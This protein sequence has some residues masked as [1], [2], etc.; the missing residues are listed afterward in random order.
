MT[1]PVFIDTNILVYAHDADAGPKH[2]VARACRP[3]IIIPLDFSQED[4][5]RAFQKGRGQMGIVR[6]LP[7]ER[8]LGV[9]TL[10]DVLDS[11]V[12]D[13]REAKLR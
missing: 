13:V 6:E 3:S 7:G 2:E 1:A 11:L 8:T 4:I 12:D 10:E 5:L 9:V